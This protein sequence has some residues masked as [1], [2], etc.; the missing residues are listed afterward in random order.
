MLHVGTGVSETVLDTCNMGNS[1]ECVVSFQ[2]PVVHRVDLHVGW[3]SGCIRDNRHRCPSGQTQYLVVIRVFVTS[4]SYGAQCVANVMNPQEHRPR[5]WPKSAAANWQ[6]CRA[7]A[8]VVPD[9]P[10]PQL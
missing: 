5:R 3:V 8:A 6:R 9:S 2:C 1:V 4:D 10:L 7:A